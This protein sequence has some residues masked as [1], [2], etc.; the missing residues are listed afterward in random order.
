[1]FAYRHA[2]H[3]GNHADVLKH[4]V[5]TQV[6]EH[7]NTKDKPYT[8]VDTHAGAG[9][10]VLNDGHRAAAP[11]KSHRSSRSSP[12]FLQGVGRL[13][14][15]NDLPPTLSQYIN[16]IRAHNAKGDLKHYPG[17][18]ALALQCIRDQDRLHLFEMHPTDAKTLTRYFSGL[19]RVTVE[20][21]NGF[22]GFKAY[23]PPPSRRAV[24]LMDPSYELK[25]DYTQTLLAVREAL[26]RFPESVLLVWHPCLAK[27]EARQLPQRLKNAAPKSWLHVQL[28][29]QA[30]D[31]A[32]FGL[33]GSGMFVFNPPWTLHDT[34]KAELPWLSK[35]LAQYDKARFSLEHHLV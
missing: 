16:L 14:S 3:A 17:S 2:F 10:Y 4:W 19:P 29:P 21:T 13:W 32:G 8:V 6:I 27:L 15:R 22:S 20:S 18:P 28:M 12:E 11:A 35:T 25:G 1:M 9:G 26:T 5:F 31:S 23:L 7:M 30:P 34:L 33:I 24:V